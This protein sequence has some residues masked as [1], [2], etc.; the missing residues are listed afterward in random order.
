MKKTYS[1]ILLSA[2]ILLGGCANMLFKKG[3]QRFDSEA[4]SEAATFYQKALDKKP[5]AGAKAKLAQTYLKLNSPK[6]AEELFREVVTLPESEPV[7]QFYFG[8]V[9]MQSRKYEEAGKAFREYARTVPDDKLVQNM[10]TAC[11]NYRSFE[12]GLDTCAFTFKKIETKS[13]ASAYGAAPFNFGYVFAAETVVEDKKSIDKYTGQTY[14][15]LHYFKRDAKTGSWS[16]PA[17][18][19]GG[20]NSELHDAFATFSADGKTVYF[21]RSNQ[22]KGKAK[23]NSKNEITLKILKASFIDG[24]WTNIEE[25]PFNND[26]FSNAHPALS[27]D[28]K[29][30]FFSSDRPGGFG[31]SDLYVSEWDGNK[32]GEPVN[33]GA[34]VNTS[35]REGYPWVATDN[36]LFFSSDGQPG[37]GGLDVFKTKGNSSSWSKPEN[38]KTPVNSSKDD[39]S[40]SVDQEGKYAN[41]SSSRQ[42]NEN[43]LK[44]ND[45]MYEIY[46]KDPIVKVSVCVFKSDSA[47]RFAGA[48]VRV[49]NDATAETD[50]ALTDSRGNVTFWLK[51]EADFTILATSKKFITNS[52]SVSTRGKFCK[53]VITT[54]D[55]G[56][57]IFLDEADTTGRKE[58]SIGDIFYDYDKWNIRKDAELNLDKLVKLLRNNPGFT[59]E[60]GSH[61]DC[62]GTDEYNQRLSENRAKAVVKYCINRDIKAKRL[63]YKGYGESDPI[64]KCV[65]E[66]CTEEQHQANRRTTF[67]IITDKPAPSGNK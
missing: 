47:T 38:L 16:T 32:W 54:C 63:Q 1:V 36:T 26:D 56:K 57:K 51:G 67:R 5:I 8:R 39:F 49:K 31:S 29:M 53:D 27:P 25:F 52:I 41:I 12:N 37:L 60:L 17:L 58:Y 6:K 43:D 55:E 19:N 10:I 9:L 20:V 11:D 15:D 21:T 7:N 30:L 61:T 46:Y 33:L 48:M 34:S 66:Q 45:N 13:F 28:G 3:N 35:G 24:E 22:L 50:S 62:R 14:L 44:G 64:Q 65:C 40:Y 18:L 59:V 4:Y 2:S 23:K 42:A